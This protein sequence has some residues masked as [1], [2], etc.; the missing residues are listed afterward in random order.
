MAWR[1]GPVSPPTL[2]P[3]RPSPGPEVSADAPTAEPRSCGHVDLETTV[4]QDLPCTFHLFEMCLNLHTPL[5]RS[6]APL[7]G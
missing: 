6:N 2:A 1:A 7:N 4:L 3:K 5:K